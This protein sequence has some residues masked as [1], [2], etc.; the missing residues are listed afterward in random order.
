MQPIFF[1]VYMQQVTFYGS[2]LTPG[3]KP[4]DG[5]AV[6]IE[7]LEM[8]AIVHNG[9]MTLTGTDG[10]MV[11]AKLG[12]VTCYIMLIA[13]IKWFKPTLYQQFWIFIHPKSQRKDLSVERN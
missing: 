2:S 10:K 12:C 13:V 9:G 5:S 3:D 7:G 8:P 6:T 1:F 4:P 11:S